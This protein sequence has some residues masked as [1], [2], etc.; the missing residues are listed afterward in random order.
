MLP[1]SLQLQ[2]ATLQLEAAQ[3]QYDKLLIGS[4]EDIIAGAYAQLAQARAQLERLE[5]G[6]KDAQI[7]AAEAQVKQAETGLYLAH[8]QL[9]KANITSPIDGIVSQ[10]NT[11]QGAMV[12]PGSPI[13]QLLSEEVDIVVA[14]EEYLLSQIEIGAPALI[15][16]NAYPDKVF[17][18]EIALIAPELEPSTRTVQVTVRPTGDAAELAPGMFATVEFLR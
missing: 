14:V 2:Q 13:A 10:V 1:E 11:T 15:T 18:A 16:V 12:A 4:T 17:E 6:A 7:Q 3:A 8:L 5:E 9:D